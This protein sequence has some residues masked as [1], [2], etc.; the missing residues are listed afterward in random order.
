[1]TT[2]TN[3]GPGTKTLVVIIAMVLAGSVTAAIV[4]AT[5]NAWGYGI[6]AG[7]LLAGL[8]GLSGWWTS[9][10]ALSGDQRTLL[11]YMV[12]GMLARM[13][14]CGTGAV[15][16]MLTG[17]VHQN[18]FILGLLSGIG[19]FLGVEVYGL[20]ISARTEHSSAQQ[21]TRRVSSGSAEGV[22]GRV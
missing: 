22:S 8:L 19:V 3:R 2:T 13:A 9:R 6:L 18:G 20:H 15:V 10:K 1:M 7:W 17:W 21:K 12:G 5:G 11:K 4:G 14:L 16:V